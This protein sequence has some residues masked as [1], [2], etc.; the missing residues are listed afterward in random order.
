MPDD[1]HYKDAR[2]KAWAVAV[3]A[4]AEHDERGRPLCANCLRY[5]KR[6]V[7][8]VAHHRLDRLTHPELAYDASNGLPLC[9]SCHNAAHPEKGGSRK[10]KHP[11]LSPKRFY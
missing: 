5:G 2:H 8:T 7:A 1:K 6:T 9:A 4:R 3:L 10:T 11:P